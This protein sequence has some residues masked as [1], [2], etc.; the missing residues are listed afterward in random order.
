MS[1]PTIKYKTKP[2]SKEK[3]LK[4]IS[5]R[6]TMTSDE[7]KI[8]NP[9]IQVAQPTRV[10]QSKEKSKHEES[11][12]TVLIGFLGD[13]AVFDNILRNKFLYDN[14]YKAERKITDD[15][16]SYWRNKM[17]PKEKRTYILNLKLEEL[18]YTPFLQ[19]INF[20]N[21]PEMTVELQDEFIKEYIKQAI[22][23]DHFYVMWSEDLENINKLQLSKIAVE[24]NIN[25]NTDIESILQ[26]A[27]S[28][29]LIKVSNQYG[30]KPYILD[31]NEQGFV[32]EKPNSFFSQ[33][34]EEEIEFDMDESE[35]EDEEDEE[36]IDED[37]ES[38]QIRQSISDQ[39]EVIEVIPTIP[40]K[41]ISA[42][43]SAVQQQPKP[44]EKV[45]KA[46]RGGK[47]K[48]KNIEVINTLSDLYKFE[49]QQEKE[50][51]KE[52]KK[53]EKELKQQIKKTL[54]IPSYFRFA[55]YD[56]TVER[57]VESYTKKLLQ[58]KKVSSFDE[59]D[60]ET[61]KDINNIKPSIKN[62]VLLPYFK[63]Y[64]YLKTL[65]KK[66]EFDTKYQKE[67]KRKEKEEK[68]RE[69][70]IQNESKEE[71]E[72][73]IQKEKEANIRKEFEL[74]FR[75]K[76]RE[77]EK[78]SQSD[79]EKMD[80]FEEEN[81]SPENEMKKLEKSFKKEYKGLQFAILLKNLRNEIIVYGNNNALIVLQL[82]A[83]DIKTDYPM[84]YDST[85][86]LIQNQVKIL[87]SVKTKNEI[88]KQEDIG[89]KEKSEIRN[90]VENRFKKRQISLPEFIKI[91]QTFNSKAEFK[92]NCPKCKKDIYIGI[93]PSLINDKSKW[94]KCDYNTFRNKAI[95]IL[96]KIDIEIKENNPERQDLINFIIFLKPNINK[97]SL[98]FKTIKQLYD[99]IIKYNQIELTKKITN[100]NFSKEKIK[101]LAVFRKYGIN[102]IKFINASDS[103]LKEASEL[104]LKLS[105]NIVLSKYI[106]INNIDKLISELQSDLNKP[107][108]VEQETKIE[109]KSLVKP[110][111]ELKQIVK[112]DEEPKIAM[113]LFIDENGEV[114]TELNPI[115]RY[116]KLRLMVN[117]MR[118]FM[119]VGQW[120]DDKK[121]SKEV[122]ILWNRIQRINKNLLSYFEN[123]GF[124]FREN[125]FNRLSMYDRVLMKKLFEGLNRIKKV[126]DK[127]K[128]LTN[129]L[130]LYENLDESN[131]P[132]FDLDISLVI[133]GKVVPL[134]QP[135]KIENDF[136]LPAKES[137]NEDFISFCKDQLQNVLN[138][139]GIN[140]YIYDK[141]S[142]FMDNVFKPFYASTQQEVLERI[143]TF[144]CALSIPE[145]KIR[146]ENGLIAS[147]LFLT[148]DYFNNYLSVTFSND[149]EYK[150]CVNSNIINLLQRK[151]NNEEYDSFTK[152]NNSNIK[153]ICGDKVIPRE[154]MIL[155]RDDDNVYCFDFDDVILQFRIGNFINAKTGK[156][157]SSNFI[158]KFMIEINGKNGSKKYLI[159]DI[160]T[161]QGGRFLHPEDSKFLEPR[162]QDIINEKSKNI[163]DFS[164]VNNLISSCKNYIDAL[165]IPYYEMVFY[166]DGDDLYCFSKSKLLMEYSRNPY[167]GNPFEKEFIKQF[168]PQY[169]IEQNKFA[170]IDISALVD[171]YFSESKFRTE[172]KDDR[173]VD[174][175]VIE[176]EN[177]DEESEDEETDEEAKMNLEIVEAG[178]KAV[179][180]N[181]GDV[182]FM[183]GDDNDNNESKENNE[184]IEKTKPTQQEDID[185]TIEEIEKENDD[186]S[187]SFSKKNK[188]KMGFD[189]KKCEKCSQTTP[190]NNSYKTVVGPDFKHV[191]FCSS[192]CMEQ[193]SFP[194][195]RN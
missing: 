121:N 191:E 43:A 131:L 76:K 38:Q 8:I 142:L 112:E 133:S 100:I 52:K 157:F 172:P 107:V 117:K 118:T 33:N 154:K 162:Y 71:R 174:L 143:A 141:T 32:Q 63:A 176:F 77:K 147:E 186:V 179:S 127:D 171:D 25:L 12:K 182:D 10:A 87:P 42:S 20:I 108:I 96:D 128:N 1:T 40:K 45:E 23:L 195:F 84:L 34:D 119:D 18:R 170:N 150:A 9:K 72:I 81:F 178:N 21:K 88:S 90:M 185:K 29:D 155:Y 2:A 61:K 19:V 123:N 136:I 59:L 48:K 74:S 177:E 89:K 35:E 91:I 98:Y 99:V 148:T 193:Y 94:C 105:N 102:P 3:L 51:R 54:V 22:P 158:D 56:K 168:E 17:S 62:K 16:T 66:N 189:S 26:K 194:K 122:M 6:S 190:Q 78:I 13:Y 144:I 140:L 11:I 130:L 65:R 39:L 64:V 58:E 7:K 103:K 180:S 110:E 36:D 188:P 138:Q 60:E 167:T 47:G 192:N 27:I 68:E 146:I 14:K 132:D 159:Q 137:V 109:S 120:A 67:K 134:I 93:D 75:K 115:V 92:I 163:R 116:E 24:K 175:D 187:F 15:L 37:E 184:K 85:L 151:N 113:E 44:I 5:G 160:K 50:E 173:K 104:I 95:D 153:Y 164:L 79:L 70:R 156:P 145:I 4:Q 41:E 55:N 124:V 111:I 169:K 135:I 125:E 126:E 101:A 183:A 80:E 97:E 31:V 166:K 28:D 57:I 152:V 129:L 46:K 49:E 139:Q 83:Q 53:R 106:S 69:I 181:E 114:K 165:N 73:R 82:S 149:E 30:V 86:G 161:G